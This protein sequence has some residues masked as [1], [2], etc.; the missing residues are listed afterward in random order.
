MA[1]L[2]LLDLAKLNS[3]DKVVGLIE[4]VR[5]AAPE[6]DV[7]PART[8]KGTT[9]QTVLRTGLPSAGFRKV[10]EGVTPS[11]STFAS[12]LVQCFILSAR[13]EVDKALAGAFEDGE[14]SL[15]A[16][17]AKPSTSASISGPAP[18]KPSSVRSRCSRAFF[19]MNFAW[20]RLAGA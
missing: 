19:A 9:Y 13:V 17:E 7:I 12:M 2:T 10:N 6:F 18:P 4:E 14:S 8:I 3:S 15:E 1:K 20:P 5:T 16:I 11:K